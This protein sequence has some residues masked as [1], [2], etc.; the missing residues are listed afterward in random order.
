MS[1]RVGAVAYHP[2]VARIW[3]AFAAWFAARGTPITPVLFVTY[4]DQLNALF[5][6]HIQVAWNTN[7]AYVHAQQRAG[8]GCGMLAMRD[9]DRDWRSHLIVRE[10]SPA[11]HLADLSG[12]RIGLA[13]SDS[14]QATILPAYFMRQ[15]G[16]DPDRD[17]IAERLEIDL[18]KHGDT[19]G[20]EREQLRRLIRGE[21][22]A[23]VLADATCAGAFT[24]DH[25]DGVNVR[26]IWT[27]P[28]YHHCNFTVLPDHEQDASAR[29][30]E[31]LMAMRSDDPAVSDAMRDEWVG[32]WVQ[33]DERGYAA[34]YD[35]LGVP[36]R[37]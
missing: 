5:G 34:L 19:G 32:R 33:G 26:R 8:G 23:A 2:R 11:H 1:L 20:A 18:G 22:D 21:I 17:A 24:A 16:F 7:L 37:V 10:D 12:Q 31:G 30:R 3:D 9:N 35:A 6:G 14:P 36:Q 28:P 4:E 25:V 29:F 15:Q 13:S 27:T